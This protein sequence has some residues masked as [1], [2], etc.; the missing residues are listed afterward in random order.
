M[1]QARIVDYRVVIFKRLLLPLSRCHSDEHFI[2]EDIIQV[3][4]FKCRHFPRSANI[5]AGKSS[6]IKRSEQDDTVS[7]GKADVPSSQNT[8]SNSGFQSSDNHS[9]NRNT[10]VRMR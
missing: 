10:N 7:S 6:S 8:T 5:L 4:P 2:P 9:N 1:L 3:V